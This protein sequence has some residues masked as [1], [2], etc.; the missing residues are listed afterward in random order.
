MELILDLIGC[1]IPITE[2]MSS[3]ISNR[4]PKES[5]NTSEKVRNKSGDS[6]DTEKAL[7]TTTDTVSKEGNTDMIDKRRKK[8]NVVKES[9]TPPISEKNN[10][11]TVKKQRNHKHPIKQ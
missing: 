1:R 10:I 2:I 8:T 9:T 3:N 6:Y 5:D 4:L 7:V 11:D